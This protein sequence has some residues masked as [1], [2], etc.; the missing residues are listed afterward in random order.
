MSHRMKTAV[1]FVHIARSKPSSSGHIVIGH[2]AGDEIED[3]R[4]QDHDLRQAEQKDQENSAHAIEQH[5]LSSRTLLRLKAHT[6]DKPARRTATL[7]PRKDRL[8]P[9]KSDGEADEREHTF[10]LSCIHS[11]KRKRLVKEHFAGKVEKH[12]RVKRYQ[13]DQNEVDP[14]RNDPVGSA[15][16]HA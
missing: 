9:T 15:L 3:Q 13:R 16:D 14:K 1:Q 12:P 2:L 7:K 11:K 8:D 6:H 4:E 5:P 10:S